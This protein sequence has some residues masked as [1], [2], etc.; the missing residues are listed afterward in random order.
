MIYQTLDEIT[1]ACLE[2][3]K[4]F[5]E[6]IKSE[7][8][9]VYKELIGVH[10]HRSTP[11]DIFIGKGDL[12]E[13]VVQEI[14]DDSSYEL[15]LL[16]KIG[17][18]VPSKPKPGPLKKA[19]AIIGSIAILITGCY[20]SKPPALKNIKYAPKP[21]VRTL[22]DQKENLE[23]KLNQ[24]IICVALS[25]NDLTGNGSSDN[26]YKTMGR[27]ME[28]ASYGDAVRVGAGTYNI[29]KEIDLKYGVSLIGAGA[30][31]TV[32]KAAPK[33]PVIFV[34]S[35][36]PNTPKLTNRISGFTITGSSFIGIYCNSSPTEISNNVI[37]ANQTGIHC[38][39]SPEDLVIRNNLIVYNDGAIDICKKSSPTIEN[40]LIIYNDWYGVN[41]V[42]SSPKI[43][44]NTIIKNPCHG[45]V[46]FESSP[47]IKNNILWANGSELELDEK[48]QCSVSYSFIKSRLSGHFP[49]LSDDYC[50]EPGS[51]LINAGDPSILDPDGTRS[52]IGAFGG[53]N[54]RPN[55]LFELIRN[56]KKKINSRH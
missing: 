8:I 43:Y 33:G 28:I 5:Y 35:R 20:D 48:S 9:P 4:S 13:Q 16:K 38:S 23:E 53:P 11:E 47:T 49:R 18:Y 15:E 46:C 29:E 31:K 12:P 55:E 10:F 21:I 34:C 19:I 30:D 36:I 52:D 14:L 25:G 41:I 42:K 26:P 3:M 45:I 40:N 37:T 56:Y 6:R 39:V 50:L 44:N 54:A 24:K 27:A 22:N 17:V 1:D 7:I 2:E 51:S 32:I